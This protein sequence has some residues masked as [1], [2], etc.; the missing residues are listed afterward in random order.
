MLRWIW[1]CATS[2]ISLTFTWDTVK[3]NLTVWYYSD[4]FDTHLRFCRG[5][6]DNSYPSRFKV[7]CLLNCQSQVL[8]LL[9]NSFLSLFI[10]IILPISLSSVE[11]WSID[12][13]VIFYS[14]IIFSGSSVDLKHPVVIYHSWSLMAAADLW[15]VSEI[16]GG[17]IRNDAPALLSLCHSAI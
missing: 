7:I 13:Q 2:Q 17:C 3:V 11:M 10:F 4:K 5:R 12:T 14:Y 9:D 1:L 15:K 6:H 16:A 8:R